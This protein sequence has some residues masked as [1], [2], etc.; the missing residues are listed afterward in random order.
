ACDF[1]LTQSAGEEHDDVVALKQKLMHAFDA[2]A[3]KQPVPSV[4]ALIKALRKPMGGSRRE[5]R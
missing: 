1:S 4:G 5:R 3:R 2:L